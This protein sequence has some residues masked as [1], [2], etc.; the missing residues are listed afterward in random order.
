MGTNKFRNDRFVHAHSSTIHNLV[1]PPIHNGT[2]T[3]TILEY[4][5]TRSQGPRVLLLREYSGQDATG[6]DEYRAQL[7]DSAS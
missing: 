2:T 1:R 7:D 3:D 4:S 6:L 5:T